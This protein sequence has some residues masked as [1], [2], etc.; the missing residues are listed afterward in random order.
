MLGCQARL[1]FIRG[2]DQIPDALRTPEWTTAAGLAMYSA[3]LRQR[4]HRSTGPRILNLFST[5]G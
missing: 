2:V 3:K 4:R 1:G 5:H